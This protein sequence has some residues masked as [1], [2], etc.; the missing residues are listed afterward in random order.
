M[1]PSVFL[2][3]HMRAHACNCPQPMSFLTGN[4][5]E[6]T[7]VREIDKRMTGNREPGPVTRLIM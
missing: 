3:E 6:D 7:P 4:S 2:G 5:A 1:T